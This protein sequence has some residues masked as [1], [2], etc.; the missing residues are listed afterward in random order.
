M[1]CIAAMIDGDEVVMGGDSAGIGGWDLE[2]RAD[3]KVF[4]TGDY[5]I[6]YTS[7]FRMGQLLQY[8]LVPPQVI[9]LGSFDSMRWMATAFIEAVRK[10]FS[11]GGLEKKEHEV[12]SGGQ[13]LVGFNGRLFA[14]DTD[15]QV[16]ESRSSFNAVGAGMAYALG[17][18]GA[19]EYDAT[20]PS[21]EYKIRRSLEVA[22]QF[23]AAVRGPFTILRGGKR[24]SAMLPENQPFKKGG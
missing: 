18:L 19:L 7:S 12:V 20:E 3:S 24:L 8:R 1:T 23:S 6:G 10:V 16:R 4:T 21:K 22:E 11:E 15:Y 14:I 5:I 13:F 17:A 9:P 2:L